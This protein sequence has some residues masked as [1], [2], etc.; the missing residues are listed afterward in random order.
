MGA[1]EGR[2]ETARLVSVD[3]AE[4]LKEAH[5]KKKKTFWFKKKTKRLLI[6]Y[7]IKILGVICI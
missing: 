1:E 6:C 3:F 4:V 7:V 2:A 5:C